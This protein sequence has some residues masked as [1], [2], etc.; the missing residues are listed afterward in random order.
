M[1]NALFDEELTSNQLL[2]GFQMNEV[3]LTTGL[4]LA[5]VE[6]MVKYFSNVKKMHTYL[7]SLK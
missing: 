2:S 1:L 7:K 3:A 6:Q 4:T 5:K